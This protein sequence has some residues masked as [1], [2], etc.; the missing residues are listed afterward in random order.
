S[1]SPGSIPRRRRRLG[2]SER[3]QTDVEA[4]EPRVRDAAVL[5]RVVG[6]P[7]DRGEPGAGVGA[8]LRHLARGRRRDRR[9]G[10]SED[11]DHHTKGREDAQLPPHA[12]L[13]LSY[14]G[15]PDPESR[16]HPT[17]APDAAGAPAAD[18]FAR[19]LPELSGLLTSL[20]C[21]PL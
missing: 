5:D 2:R 8:L 9:H 7:T 11:R 1:W 12:F 10:E 20:R 17:L 21:F 4:V 3:L 19:L 6:V 14:A 15:R 13:L 16:R 18:A